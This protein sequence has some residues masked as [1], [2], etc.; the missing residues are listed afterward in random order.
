[1]TY[2][3]RAMRRW[4]EVSTADTARVV[5]LICQEIDKAREYITSEAS[6]E[7]LAQFFYEQLVHE[8]VLASVVIVKWAE[9][10]HPAAD[11]AIR[12]FGREMGER[13][14]FD[15][16]LVSVRSYYLKTAGQPFVPFPQGRHVV[17]NMM[18]DL[19]LPAVTARVAESTRL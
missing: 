15:D 1:M 8:Q 7:R 3:E 5:D 11:R 2:V 14:R 19:W 6:W 9:A 12:R 17:A 18:R 13:S 16:M 4:T 10:G